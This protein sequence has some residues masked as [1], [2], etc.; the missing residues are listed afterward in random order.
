MVPRIFYVFIKSELYYNLYLKLKIHGTILF[1]FEKNKKYYV[2]VGLSKVL[3]FLMKKI[4]IK[5]TT[6]LMIFN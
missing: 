3:S 1:F 2:F 5:I 6:V 4:Q